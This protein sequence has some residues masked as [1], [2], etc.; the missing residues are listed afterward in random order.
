MQKVVII[1]SSLTLS[2]AG[3]CSREY[4]PALKEVH[5]YIPE[6]VEEEQ[7]DKLSL[8]LEPESAAIFCQYM[9]QNQSSNNPANDGDIELKS[10]NY[11]IV[12]I[13][14]GTVDISAHCLARGIE[15][16]IKV[17]HPPTGNNCGGTRVNDNFKIFLE[18]MVKD[19]E[20]H[21]FTSTPDQL[22]NSRNSY[23]L[24]LLLNE[25]FEMQK[26]VFNEDDTNY[27]GGIELPSAF[28]ETYEYELLQSILEDNHDSAVELVDQDLRISHKVM[29]GFFKDVVKGIVQSISET[30]KDVGNIKYIYLV[31]GFGGTKYVQKVIKE[32][33]EKNDIRCIVPVEPA[34]AVVRGAALFKLNPNIIECRKV[35][36]TYGI[37]TNIPFK[38]G[39]HDPKYK[40]INDDNYEKCKNIFSTVVEKGDIVGTGEVFLTTFY[41][42]QHNQKSMLIKFYSSQETDIFYVTGEW[43]IGKCEPR[44][45][46]T[47]IGQIIIDMPVLEGDKTRSVDVMFSFSHTEIQVR[48]FD[49][50]SKTEVKIVLDFVTTE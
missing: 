28:F 5:N 37:D 13:G 39:L 14:G 10:T 18:D 25:K 22:T 40:W 8:A 33:F 29:S 43:G 4:C 46:V 1:T 3:L 12:D 44:H 15:P 23:I 21:R 32:E 45:T 31:G 50:T 38:P 30:L 6:R 36:A 41:P 34:Y 42:V 7:P 9:S 48:A 16:H 24:D 2:Q 26:K 20:F 19:T 17:I 47:K 27:K 49:K 11:L 35:D